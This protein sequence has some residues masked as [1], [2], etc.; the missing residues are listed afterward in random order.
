[1]RLR[2]GHA[3]SMAVPA[4]VASMLLGCQG[5]GESTVEVGFVTTGQALT[6]ASV[7]AGAVGPHLFLTVARVDVHVAGEGDPDDDHPAGLAGGPASLPSGGWITVFAGAAKLDLLDTSAVETLLGS[8]ATPSGKVTQI[9]LVL[10]DATWTDGTVT[11]PVECPSCS[12][13]GL[14]IVTMGKLVVP[15]G[16]TLHVKLD[17]NREQS[18]SQAANGLR[19]DPVVKIAP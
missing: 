3:G 9:R 14:K 4:L 5:S 1:M 2:F 6:A 19:L 18:I 12:Q 13:T 15:P 8:V 17:L 11:T 10:T 16:G 7:D